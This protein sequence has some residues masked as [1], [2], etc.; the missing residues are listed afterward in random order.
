MGPAI[1]D[2]D[3]HF[4]TGTTDYNVLSALFEGLVGEDPQDLSPVPGVANSWSTSPDGLTYTFQLRP[5][6][7]WSNGDP[8]IAQDFA[9]SWQRVLTHS[10][11]AEYSYLLYIVS[12][13]E[14]FHRGD[15]TDFSTVGVRVLDPLTLEITL[16]YPAPYFL[17][18]LEH[19]MW[20]PVHL[21]SIR[22]VGDLYTRGTPWARP[23]KLVCNGPF[24]LTAWRHGER[25]SVDRNIHYWDAS[26][27]PPR[28]HRIPSVRRSR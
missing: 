26:Q 17:S 5:N 15:T 6:A 25:I 12:G 21:S 8:L 1:A 23:G 20:F 18:L 28:S 22:T 19:W 14:A 7:R 3:S 9:D 11:T 2:L 24:T 27:R 10:L 13:A 4:V 16:E